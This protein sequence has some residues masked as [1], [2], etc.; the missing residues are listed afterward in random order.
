MTRKSKLEEIKK[1]KISNSGFFLN[2]SWL[3]MSPH[4]PQDS[5]NARNALYNTVQSEKENSSGIKIHGNKID[6]QELKSCLISTL[7]LNDCN[8]Q[9][10]VLYAQKDCWG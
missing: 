8:I 9:K 6:T 2:E 1:G 3:S 5:V 7:A 10:D 4:S